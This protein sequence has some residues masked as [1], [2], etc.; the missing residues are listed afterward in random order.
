MSVL[1]LATIVEARGEAIGRRL[2]GQIVVMT[3]PNDTRFGLLVDDLG[4]IVEVLATRLAPL[5]PMMT[6]QET[7]ADTVIAYDGS[8]DS[9]L[10]VVLSAERLYG[11]LAMPTGHLIAS[12]ANGKRAGSGT[13]P[14]AKS[15]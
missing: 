5:P 6:R 7:F 10:L 11:N 13:M 14:V 8:D 2:S 15:A 12:G 3:L 1:D 9:S 4:E